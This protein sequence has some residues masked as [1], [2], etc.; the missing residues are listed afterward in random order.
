[1]PRNRLIFFL[2]CEIKSM[3]GSATLPA[4]PTECVALLRFSNVT[5]AASL[6][7]S[8]SRRCPSR[9]PS[10]TVYSVIPQGPLSTGTP[11]AGPPG[12]AAA[13]G[14]PGGPGRAQGDRHATLAAMG[15]DWGPIWGC[16][17]RFS[18][19][20]TAPPA[21]EV[22]RLCRLQDDL[23]EDSQWL[24]TAASVEVWRTSKSTPSVT[25]AT[26]SCLFQHRVQLNHKH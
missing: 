18:S 7:L 25:Q 21:W 24:A 26:W 3:R 9:L 22:V 12:G 14:V 16:P 10:C 15:R 2:F 20:H 6:S 11:A 13:G 5:P 17:P 8:S 19:H 1:M 4:Q 23:E